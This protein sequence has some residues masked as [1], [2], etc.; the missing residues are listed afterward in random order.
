[1]KQ[2]SLFEGLEVTPQ[3]QKDNEK[4]EQIKV[5]SPEDIMTISQEKPEPIFTPE[6]EWEAQWFGSYWWV[7]WSPILTV[8]HPTT[9]NLISFNGDDTDLPEIADKISEIL[10]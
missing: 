1:M 5:I 2:L 3:L 7:Q 8:F 9:G 10:R 4:F 6:P